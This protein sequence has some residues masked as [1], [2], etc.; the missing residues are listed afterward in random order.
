MYFLP[1]R[2]STRNELARDPFFGRLTPSDLYARGQHVSQDDYRSLYV[3]GLEECT[4]LEMGKIEF[5]MK[6]TSD[7]V[8]SVPWWIHDLSVRLVPYRL[9]IP[10]VH[11]WIRA[12]LCWS[13]D[14]RIEGGMPHTLQN[15]IV[16]PKSMRNILTSPSTTTNS[17][18]FSMLQHE[19]IHVLQRAYPKA[20]DRL[21]ATIYRLTPL[22]LDTIRYM[23]GNDR[24]ALIRTNPDIDRYFGKW[25][26]RRSTEME[27]TQESG[28][29]TGQLYHQQKPLS[30]HD[31]RVIQFTLETGSPLRI[32]VIPE[33]RGEQLEHPHER[34][35][36][37]ITA[38]V[39]RMSQRPTMTI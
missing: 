16:I 30:L 6:K 33:K 13:N 21:Y 18:F 22:S 31:S 24:M 26:I 1:F 39:P 38:T 12:C 29:W 23:V 10:P 17:A 8:V 28:E 37:M 19:M 34:F 32:R 27:V 7:V 36:T 15:V 11:Q 2:E 4:F 3:N 35:A 14:D 25:V 9:S 5:P 20:F